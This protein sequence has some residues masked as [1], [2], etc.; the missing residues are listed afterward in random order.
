MSIIATHIF[1]DPIVFATTCLLCVLLSLGFTGA[2]GIVVCL[3]CVAL[4][5]GAGACALYRWCFAR[6]AVRG[7]GVLVS[8]WTLVGMVSMPSFLKLVRLLLAAVTPLGVTPVS[9]WLGEVFIFIGVL[10][11][12]LMFSVLALELPLRWAL[13][14]T[15]VI[16][17]GVLRALRWIAT[18]LVMVA[19][20]VV[21][22][23]EALVRLKS[24]CARMMV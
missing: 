7:F 8:A 23:E 21:V 1:G 4:A 18:L 13:A 22:Q 2:W 11:A 9:A 3:G 6:P 15:R 24:L 17:D 10:V 19:G 20:H 12:V 14:D 5:S 16:D